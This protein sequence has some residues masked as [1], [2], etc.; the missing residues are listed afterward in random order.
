MN[1]LSVNIGQVTTQPWRNGTPSAL[2]KTPIKE[3]VFIDTLGLSGDKQADRKNHGG[4]DKAVFILPAA[5]YKRFKIQQ[6]FGFLGENLTISDRDE[7]QICLGDRLQIGDVLLEVT[8]PRSPCWKLGEHASIQANW[9]MATFL[10]AYSQEG[11]VGF[12]CRVI[13]SGLVQSGDTIHWLPEQSDRGKLTI[14][15][16]FMAKQFH[17]TPEHIHQLNIAIKHPALSE[18]WRTEIQTLLTQYR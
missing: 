7:S 17:K 10:Q 1:I 12:Y 9:T 6:P 5:H 2:N 13:Q 14:Q 3:V 16:L 15:A 18:A 8:Q 4:E 11:Y